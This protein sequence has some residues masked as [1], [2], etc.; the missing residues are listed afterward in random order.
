[1]N[2]FAVLEPYRVVV[3]P[4]LDDSVDVALPALN[5]LKKL[6]LELREVIAKTLLIQQI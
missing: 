2:I 3:L 1:M 4:V 6:L 5:I